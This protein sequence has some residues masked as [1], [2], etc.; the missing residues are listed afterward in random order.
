M[1]HKKSLAARILKTSKH[2]VRFAA[3]ALEDIK[4]AITRSDLRGLIAVKKITTSTKNQQSRGGARKIAT[5]KR[6]GR[7][8]GR[9]SKKGKKYSV[10]PRKSRWMA[11]VRAQ[12]KFLRE[13]RTNGKITPK[14]FQLLYAKSKGGYFRNKRHIKLYITEHNLIKNGK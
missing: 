6:K 5:Q 14:N 3:D 2:K 12:R 4:K 9:G 10:V 7:Q 8:K 11:K 1:R 13:L